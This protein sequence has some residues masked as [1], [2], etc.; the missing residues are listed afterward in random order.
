MII[1]EQHREYKIRGNKLDSNNYEDLSP[2]R[3][4]SLLNNASVFIV[5]HY[6]ELSKFGN[7]QWQKDLFGTLL[8]KYPDQ[9]ALVPDDTQGQQ[10]EYNLSNLKYDY[11]H[12]DSAYVQCG[13]LVVPVSLTTNDQMQKKNDAYQKPSFKWKRL[14]GHIGKSSNASST[15]LYVY[16][17]VD[18]NDKALRLEYVKYP[19][20]VFFGYYDSTEYLDCKKREQLGLPVEDCSGYYNVADAPVNS[21]LPLSMHSL[22]VDVA[23]WLGTGKTENQFLNQFL[24]NKISNLP[25]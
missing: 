9:P 18:L 16:S 19:K 20:K 25:R 3:I 12:L 2:S 24:T 4:D 17:D 7:S 1:A 22:Q 13:N 14:L 8:V 11:H 10:Y 6:G 23:V 21:E 5:E 15:S